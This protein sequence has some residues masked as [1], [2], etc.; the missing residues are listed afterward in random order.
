MAQEKNEAAAADALADTNGAAGA[1]E[2]SAPE[3]TPYT[4]PCDDCDARGVREVRRTRSGRTADVYC[5]CEH[6]RRK[7][8]EHYHDLHDTFPGAGVPDRLQGAGLASFRH[9][10]REAYGPSGERRATSTDAYAAAKARVRGDAKPTRSLC[11]LGPNGTGKTG[12]L[13]AIAREV[14][15]AGRLPL[16]VKYHTLIREGVQAGYGRTTREGLDLSQVRLRTAQRAD[17]LFLDDV[18]DPFGGEGEPKDR[19]D[20]LFQLIAA[21]HEH[22][23]PTLL[24]TNFRD[25]DRMQDQLDRRI[26][27]RIHEMCDLAQHTLPS[28]REA[29]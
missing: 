24:T 28:L 5:D 18:G 7:Q 13:V 8:L 14:Y 10:Y 4:A 21:R 16:F 17:V 15:K 12:L 27:D 25:L 22:G 19:R 1:P 26:T 3:P 9:A 2:R 20:L 6:G 29:N 11:L 23:R